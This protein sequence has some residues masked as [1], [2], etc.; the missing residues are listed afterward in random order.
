MEEKGTETSGGSRCPADT[1][2]NSYLK[3]ELKKIQTVYEVYSV[4]ILEYWTLSTSTFLK[5]IY[6]F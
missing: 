4:F 5:Y 3:F 1:E 6:W 2:M